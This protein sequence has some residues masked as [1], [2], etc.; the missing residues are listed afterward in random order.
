MKNLKIIVI[1]LL[2]I[3]GG[4]YNN[5]QSD[6]THQYG[7]FTLTNANTQD[8]NNVLKKNYD[9]TL[10]EIEDIS[11]YSY[12][13]L[14]KAYKNSNSLVEA[15]CDVCEGTE[16]DEFRTQDQFFDEVERSYGHRFEISE[17]KDILD[18]IGKP[19]YMELPSYNDIEL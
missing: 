8:V 19:E 7:N 15:V 13:D 3:A 10:S 18:K 4:I 17:V 16:F 2:V 5:V 14:Y 12:D 11:Q 9:K 1:S 6:E